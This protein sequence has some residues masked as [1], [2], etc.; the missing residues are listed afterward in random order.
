MSSLEIKSLSK[1]FSV[2]ALGRSVVALD[3]VSVSVE[4]GT[5]LVVVGASGSGK[6]TLLKCINRT[7]VVDQ[8]TIHFDVPGS[9]QVDLGSISDQEMADLREANIG[10]VSQFLR[11]E[12]RRTARQVVAREGRRKGLEPERADDAA[13]ESLAR[14]GLGKDL[15]D[16]FPALMSGG[17]QQRVNLAAA[18]V[19][20]PALLLLDEPVASLDR[21]SSERALGLVE[22]AKAGGTTVVSVFH[23]KAAASRLGDEVVVLHR[24]VLVDRGSA[25]EVAW[26]GEGVI[27]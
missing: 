17:E 24:G 18:T 22:R 23:D 11:P 25:D 1:T 19:V 2:H 14:V 20:P 26:P 3:G 13:R 6:S 8:G 15:W 4:Q 10:Y 7:N 27:S 12:P 5:H 9:G 21:A 16:S